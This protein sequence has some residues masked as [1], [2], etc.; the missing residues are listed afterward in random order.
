M[1]VLHC[2]YNFTKMTS[3]VAAQVLDQ[4]LQIKLV[5]GFN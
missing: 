4:T 2:F 1:E 3:N 5:I